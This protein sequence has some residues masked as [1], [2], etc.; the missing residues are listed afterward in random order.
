[1]KGKL[2]EINSFCEAVGELSNKFNI[3]AEFPP[4]TPRCFK[5]GGL[6]VERTFVDTWEKNKPMDVNKDLYC[7]KCDIRYGLEEGPHDFTS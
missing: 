1:M 3:K 6:L 2:K 7:P 4:T 5:C